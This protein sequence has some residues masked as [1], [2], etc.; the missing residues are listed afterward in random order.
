M[1]NAEKKRGKWFWNKNSSPS[2]MKERSQKELMK[3]EG[4]KNSD[5]KE[6]ANERKEFKKEK[7]GKIS[8]YHSELQFYSNILGWNKKVRNA[9]Q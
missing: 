3:K 2:I 8:K 1:K 4:K 5:C 6:E 9:F 7:D